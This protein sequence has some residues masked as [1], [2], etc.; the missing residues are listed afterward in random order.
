M[1]Q[2][3]QSIIAS[4]V[5]NGERV[6]MYGDRPL[7]PRWDLY[8]HSTGGFDWGHYGERCNQLA[9]AV[10]AAVLGDDALAML[11]YQSY[12]HHLIAKIQVEN[13]QLPAAEVLAWVE[14]QPT[15]RELLNRN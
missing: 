8:V 12:L 9:L 13:W 5:S 4:T 14:D 10:V 7:N 11:L 6:V 1:I 15:A 3:N 2:R